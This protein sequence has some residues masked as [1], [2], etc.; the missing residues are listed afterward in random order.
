MKLEDL[1]KAK[2]FTNMPQIPR[3]IAGPGVLDR[4]GEQTKREFRTERKRDFIT[5][6]W[7]IQFQESYGQCNDT[8]RRNI[9]LGAKEY[10]DATSL[11][12]AFIED[13][14][15]QFVLEEARISLKG[16]RKGLVMGFKVEIYSPTQIST[17]NKTLA[18]FLDGKLEEMYLVP[19]LYDKDV[20]ALVVPREEGYGVVKLRE[21]A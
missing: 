21:E 13:I 10:T 20:I 1:K 9:K 18:D 5:S 17:N 15:Y 8:I 7:Y 19:D 2:S 12:D 16:N 4:I 3:N 6:F 11:E 14:G